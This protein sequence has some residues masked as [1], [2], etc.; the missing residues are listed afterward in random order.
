MNLHDLRRYTDDPMF[1]IWNTVSIEGLLG[2]LAAYKDQK[3]SEEFTLAL[4]LLENYIKFAKEYVEASTYS[5][6]DLE[7]FYN[8]FRDGTSTEDLFSRERPW[9]VTRLRMTWRPTFRPSREDIVCFYTAC[10]MGGFLVG[11]LRSLFL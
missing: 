8:A 2:T 11:F 1:H 4:S 10:L 3:E 9:K 5:V 6:A 7:E